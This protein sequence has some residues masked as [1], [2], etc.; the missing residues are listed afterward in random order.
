MIVSSKLFRGNPI[1]RALMNT[2]D[3]YIPD[4]FFVDLLHVFKVCFSHL[5]SLFKD[6]PNV[7]RININLFCDHRTQMLEAK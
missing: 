2:I 5:S 1:P 4:D 6:E 3:E 7:L